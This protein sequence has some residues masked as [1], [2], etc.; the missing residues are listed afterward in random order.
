MNVGPGSNMEMNELFPD[1]HSEHTRLI[2]DVDGQV[3]DIPGVDIGC[4]CVDNGHH[5]IWLGCDKIILR[6]ANKCG[7]GR[8]RDMID[9]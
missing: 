4:I 1:S 8:Y 3:L 6:I 7:S 2:D 9:S 5:E